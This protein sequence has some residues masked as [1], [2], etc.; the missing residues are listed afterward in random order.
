MPNQKISALTVSPAQAG[1]LIPIARSGA[2]F[3]ITAGSIPPS[4]LTL[5][6]NAKYWTSRG[7][8]GVSSQTPMGYLMT[9]FAVGDLGDPQ[10]AIDP[11]GNL[12]TT[13]GSVDNT[14]ATAYDGSTTPVGSTG[15]LGT[16]VFSCKFSSTLTQTRWIGFTDALLGAPGTAMNTNTPAANVLGFIQSNTLSAPTHWFAVAQTDATHQTLVDTGIVADTTRHAFAFVKSGG[17]V[18]FYID[19][20]Q[21][22]TISTN[23]PAG[24]T[25]LA[26]F[27][28]LM[29]HSVG[30]ISFTVY[31]L[32][33][34]VA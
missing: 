22:G 18:T 34:D 29:N 16:A 13:Q 25:K 28:Y 4:S 30:Q 32:Y 21:V 12:L 2:N 23:I 14:P 27:I 9:N 6:K 7:T 15:T 11:P 33:W 31:S 19:G 5:F 8:N 20:V 24:A 17:T 3:A 1:D 10:T 26:Q